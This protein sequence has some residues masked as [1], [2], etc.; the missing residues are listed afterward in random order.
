MVDEIENGFHHSVV[1][2]DLGGYRRDCPVNF[3][4]QVFATTHSYVSVCE[5]LLMQALRRRRGSFYHRLA[6]G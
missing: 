2:K 3:G 1:P 6:G 4:V 5:S